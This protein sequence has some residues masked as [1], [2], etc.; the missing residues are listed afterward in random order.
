MS[1]QL[2]AEMAQKRTR[3]GIAARI[4]GEGFHHGRPPLGFEREDGRL[5]EAGNF[6]QV[7]SVLEMVRKEELSKRKAD[8]EPDCSR[9]TIDRALDRAELYGVRAQVDSPPSERLSGC[10]HRRPLKLTIKPES[11]GTW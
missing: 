10:T 11:A 9:P 6:D 3:E 1:A 7:V 4:D 5:I 8:G 2:E